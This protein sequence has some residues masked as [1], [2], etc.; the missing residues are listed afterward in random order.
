MRWAIF[1]IPLIFSQCT[2]IRDANDPYHLA[3]QNTHTSWT[4]PEKI[5]LGLSQKEE[6]LPSPVIDETHLHSLA[7]VLDLGLFFN[8]KTKET[9]AIA[10]QKAAL[11]GQS[12]Q[13][14][15]V[16]SNFTSTWQ[17]T[18][19]PGLFI[20]QSY[21]QFTTLFQNELNLS[22]TFLDFGKTNNTSLTALYA[23]Y[24]ADWTHN[25]EIQRVIQ[26]LMD[27]YFNVVY[28]KQLLLAD[29][30]NIEDALQI[31]K[32]AE[33]KL[34][35][36]TT[37]ISDLLQ[38]KSNYLDQKLT[39]I[40]QE[41]TLYTA[42]SN[43]VND[44]GIPATYKFQLQEFPD[45]FEEY[46]Q[47]DFEDLFA[48]AKKHRP[49]YLAA[50]CDVES[51][52]YNIKAMQSN[53]LPTL[54]GNFSIGKTRGNDGL[55]DD[56]DFSAIVSLSVPLFQGFFQQNQVRQARSLLAESKAKLLEI[57]LLMTKQIDLYQKDISFALNSLGAAKEFLLT[58]KED[59]RVSLSKYKQGTNTII[60]VINAQTNIVDALAKVILSK[61]DYFVSLANLA[62]AIGSLN[63]NAKE[64]MQ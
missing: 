7:E 37:D 55:K 51:N 50:L 2:H 46:R 53:Y 28:Q 39:L 45:S 34:E 10:R 1:L 16:L 25:S 61:R 14:D 62:Y 43:L 12:L 9:W 63:I 35:V 33:H 17:R 47:R 36:G 52:A 8:P 42:F 49:D 11:Y 48:I 29:Q 26:T 59:F 4:P 13:N 23:L 30:A 5:L 54:D 44:I 58:A 57:E 60:D 32:E 6:K 19:E 40:S 24:E 31:L 22:Y 21:L 64:F 20:N 27:D 15:F 3:P 56:Y 18:K 41:Q 38:A